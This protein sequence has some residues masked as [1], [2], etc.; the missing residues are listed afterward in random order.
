[1]FSKKMMMIAAIFAFIV[2]NIIALI[3]SARYLTSATGFR[4]LGIG[5]VS[6]LQKTVTECVQV[7]KKIWLH[8]FFLISAEKDNDTLKK[9]L[10]ESLYNTGQC[11]EL[12]IS[13]LRFRKLLDFKNCCAV[14]TIAA[15]VTGRDPS[16]W[17]KTLIIDKGTFEGVVKGLSVIVPEGVVG[18]VIEASIHYA[19]ILLIIDSNSAVDALVQQTRAHGIIKGD[20]ENSCFLKYVSRKE[21]VSIGDAVISSGLDN[22]FPKGFQIGKISDIIKNKSGIFQDIVV[23]PFVNFDKIEEVLVVLDPPLQNNYR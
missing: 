17:C 14:R 6:P 9:S 21:T 22:V 12:E 3:I 13:N 10:A 23:V 1:M 16:Q 2:I 20:S 19:K 7:V 11:K 4:N 8:Y 18:Q 5:F 15:E